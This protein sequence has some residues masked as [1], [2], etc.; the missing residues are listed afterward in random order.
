MVK[1]EN[2]RERKKERKRFL[3]E[4]PAKAKYIRAIF[5]AVSATRPRADVAYCIH[6]LAMRSAKT[7]NWVVAL[8]TLIVLHHA[9]REVN[10]T[11]HEEIMNYGRSRNHMLNLSHFKDDSCPNGVVLYCIHHTLQSLI[12]HSN[13]V[14]L[15]LTDLIAPALTIAIATANEAATKSMTHFSCFCYCYYK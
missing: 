11:F 10:P 2:R 5:S 6:G 1:V 9:L 15:Y 3:I 13:G 12:L 14:V 7:H 4:R 8:K